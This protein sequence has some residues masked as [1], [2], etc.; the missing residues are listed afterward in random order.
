MNETRLRCVAPN[1]NLL[2]SVKQKCVNDEHEEAQ[3]TA[4]MQ[5]IEIIVEVTMDGQHY[6]H[7]RTTL[8]YPR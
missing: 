4:G 3:E 8:I 6:T 5:Q 2:P 1:L 7:D